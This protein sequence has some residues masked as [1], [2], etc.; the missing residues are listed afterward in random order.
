M[1][2]IIDTSVILTEFFALFSSSSCSKELA[3]S[4]KRP[5]SSQFFRKRVG[6]G[7]WSGRIRQTVSGGTFASS[8]PFACLQNVQ[9]FVCVCVCTCN[10]DRICPGWSKLQRHLMLVF[11]HS[12][13]VLVGKPLQQGNEKSFFGQRFLRT[14][15][16]LSC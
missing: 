15:I 5:T 1:F 2:S 8:M 14:I 9:H 10:N 16:T 7:V 3:N 11:V 12:Q 13:V 4:L 6:V